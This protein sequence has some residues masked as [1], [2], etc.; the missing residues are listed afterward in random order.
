[1]LKILIVDDRSD[2]LRKIKES[3]L[4]LPEVKEEGIQC[5]TSA[6]DARRALELQYFDLLILDINLPA[7]P[8]D[9]PSA[10]VG[11][12]LLNELNS[13][14]RLKKPYH[15]I[16]ITAYDSIKIAK[17]KDFA[18]NLWT[19]ILYDESN[20]NWIKNLQ[21]KIE[22]LIQSKRDIST[23]SDYQYDIAIIT[24]LRK[25][26]LEAIL[27]LDANWISFKQPGDSI[28]F[29]KGVFENDNK[30]LTVVCASC[31]QM[32][33]VATSVLTSKMIFY[34]KPRYIVMTGICAGT[35]KDISGFGDIIAS[36]FSFDYDQGKKTVNEDGHDEFL[37]D[38]RQVAI[39]TELR[40]YLNACSSS[41]KYLDDIQKN[42]PLSTARSLLN[43]HI[44]PTASGASVLANQSYIDLITKY[45]RK[46]IG[47]DME[48]YGLYYTAENSIRPKPLGF[49]SLKSISDFAGIDKDDRHQEYAS[50]TSASFLYNFALE[51]F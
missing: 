29:F 18:D 30:K 33:M 12:K 38:H 5:V 25:P 23:I 19:I 36:E 27:K 51:Y 16:G 49:L 34:F 13:S 2:K 8:E 43:L 26:E 24:A 44:G 31:T 22:Y 7:R 50:Y 15:I 37:P 3:V 41:R 40:D 47:I 1:M 10:D 17:E 4:A 35:K 48:T 42:W 39:C 32:G 28:E 46:L 21:N 6:V 11:V 14:R 45:Q 20:I 9:L